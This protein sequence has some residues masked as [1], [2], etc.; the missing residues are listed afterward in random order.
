MGISISMLDAVADILLDSERDA[1]STSLQ[2]FKDFVVALSVDSGLP[3]REVQSR[4]VDRMLLQP[5]HSTIMDNV[6]HLD[7]YRH[8]LQIN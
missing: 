3:E 7:D 8:L 6:I 1:S 5:R 4:L 2:S